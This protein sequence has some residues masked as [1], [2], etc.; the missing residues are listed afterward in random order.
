MNRKDVKRTTDEAHEIVRSLQQ[1]VDDLPELV[2]RATYLAS[3]GYPSNSLGGGGNGS[4]PASS[5]TE[6]AALSRPMPD[7]VRRAVR[8]ALA[9]VSEMRVE[10]S[11]L[12]SLRRIVW[13]VEQSERGRQSQIINCANPACGDPCLPR[14]RNGRCWPCYEY[15]QAKGLERPAELVDAHR[16]RQSEKQRAS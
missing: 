4:G 13:E 7:P 11:R 14:P 1:F 15:R 2:R 16:R 10:V 3:D 8:D 12:D 6:R 5:S 9:I